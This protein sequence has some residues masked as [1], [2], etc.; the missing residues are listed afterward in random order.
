V[1]KFIDIQKIVSKIQRLEK[2][3]LAC[4]QEER[5]VYHDQVW[6]SNKFWI[7]L[8]VSSIDEAKTTLKS[9]IDILTWHDLPIDT[10][11]KGLDLDDRVAMWYAENDYLTIHIYIYPDVTDPD[12]VDEEKLKLAQALFPEYVIRDTWVE[13]RRWITFTASEFKRC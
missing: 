5:Y 13:Q 1:V 4:Y 12:K 7:S 2:V 11:E 6:V 10:F 3:S 8:S 9:I